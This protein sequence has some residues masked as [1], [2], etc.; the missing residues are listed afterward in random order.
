MFLPIYVNVEEWKSQEGR[1]G[2]WFVG[3]SITLNLSVPK[4]TRNEAQIHV[5]KQRTLYYKLQPPSYSK[6]HL[7][8]S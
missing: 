6:G 5:F 7:L 8:F 3:I 1:N 2:F 4:E